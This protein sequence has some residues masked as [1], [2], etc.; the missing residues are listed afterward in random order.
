MANE[1]NGGS[2]TPARRTRRKLA[3]ALG[4]GEHWHLPAATFGN[5][6]RPQ[7]WQRR[8]AP[9]ILGARAGGGGQ[10]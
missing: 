10:A 8:F 2:R 4:A 6:W 1:I 9:D 7:A 5:A 3:E